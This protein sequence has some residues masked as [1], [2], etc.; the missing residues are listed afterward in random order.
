MSIYSRFFDQVCTAEPDK[1]PAPLAAVL[2]DVEFSDGRF[3]VYDLMQEIVARA[4]LPARVR[5]RML[6]DLAKKVC[7][8]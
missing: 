2:H 8:P 1:D 4:D 5:L 7:G 6:R 3:V